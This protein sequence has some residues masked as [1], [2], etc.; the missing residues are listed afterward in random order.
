MKIIDKI[1]DIFVVVKLDDGKKVICPRE[2]FPE[3]IEVGD[4][5]NVIIE[6]KEESV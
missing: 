4:A 5:I 3:R 2:I 6:K 1:E